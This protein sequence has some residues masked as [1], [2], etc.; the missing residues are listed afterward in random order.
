MSFVP[1]IFLSHTPPVGASLALD[2][3]VSHYLVTVLRLGKGAAFQ[4]FDP[5]G[6]EYEMTLEEPAPSQALAKNLRLI[7]EAPSRPLWVALGQSL[8]KAAKMDLILRQGT[9]V[10]LSQFIPIL[11]ERSVSRPEE[12]Q[13]VHKRDRWRKILIEACR[14]CGRPDLPE[15]SPLVDWDAALKLF[16]DYDLVLLPYEKEAPSLKGV[17]ES[18]PDSR[19]ILILVGPEGGWSPRE[20]EQAQARG[21]CPTHLPVPILRTETAGLTA[22]AMVQFFKGE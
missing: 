10:G 6:A 20:V 3:S 13:W 21:A 2:P 12:D 4:A 18:K 17:L 9:E 11:T 22:A 1:R 5:R 19:R 14:Q 16:Q 7:R 8:P 15:L